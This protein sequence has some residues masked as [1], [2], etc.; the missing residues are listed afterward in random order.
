MST[1]VDHVS[2]SG[3]GEFLSG[4]RRA[5]I[6]RYHPPHHHNNPLDSRDTNGIES[7][8]NTRFAYGVT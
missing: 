5:Q 7:K 4:E 1:L 8:T 2:A 6:V 3:F